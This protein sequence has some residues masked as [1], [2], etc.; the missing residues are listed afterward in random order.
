[1]EP[2][3]GI[4]VAED[5]LVAVVEPGAAVTR[6]PNDAAGHAALIAHVAPL[7]PALIVLE[8]TGGVERAVAVALAE[9]ALPV[10][11]VNPAQVRQFARGLGQRA[12][13][14]PIDAGVL[15]RFAAIVRPAVRPQPTATQR[16]LA[17]LVSRRRQVCA[18]RVAE[19]HH[20][21]RADP[22]VAASLAHVLTVLAAEQAELER[23]IAARLA[24]D[25]SLR[26]KAA[27]LESAPGIGPVVAATL[28]A[29]LPELGQLSAKQAAALVGVA[30]HTQ[31]SGRH[32]GQ[33]AI[34]GGRRPVRCALYLA[35]VTA[36]RCNP[37]L[38]AFYQR[39]LAQ[40]KPRKLALVAAAR[41][42]LGILNAM[43]RDGVSW[44]PE[45]AMP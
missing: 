39:L 33:A 6:W 24:L 13:T 7:E 41:K 8:G 45:T 25:P 32:Y 30:P 27:L 20:Q 42:L 40:H 5:E 36:V 3:I 21:R 28:L 37:V 2:C 11:V 34:G 22:C 19:Q 12:K 26:A 9:A 10:A 14:D 38:R 43:L 29:E 18:L 4:D 31:Q 23:R 16:E 35:A 15:A 44:Q 1:M 17:A